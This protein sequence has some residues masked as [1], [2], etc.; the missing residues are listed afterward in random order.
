MFRLVLTEKQNGPKS[1]KFQE[2]LGSY[3]PKQSTANFDGERIKYWISMGAQVSDTVHNLLIS[4]KIITGKKK[5]V[6]PRKTPIIKEK[7]EEPKVEETVPVS[8]EKAATPPE[9]APAK[10]EEPKEVVAEEVKA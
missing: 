10:P 9:P 3:G 1:G 2:I 7:A 5:N 8:S 6:L 4:K